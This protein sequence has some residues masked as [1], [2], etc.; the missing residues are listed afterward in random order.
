MSC[1]ASVYRL[2]CPTLLAALK[3]RLDDAVI[4]DVRVNDH[5]ALRVD[6]P[7]EEGPPTWARALASMTGREV[8]LLRRSASALLLVDLGPARYA[9][10]FGHGRRM[11][12]DRAY[13]T[14]FGL[15]I[16]LRCL[17]S[18]Q[19]REVTR[20]ELT[21]GARL[22]LTHVS[23]GTD[24]RTFGIEQAV[25]VVRQLGGRSD[26]LALN[27]LTG[28]ATIQLD[29]RDA[30]KVPLA[31]EPERL[32]TD[33]CAIEQAYHLDPVPE[34]AFIEAL[35][36]LPVGTPAAGA[37]ESVLAAALAYPTNPRLGLTLPV[38]LLGTDIARYRIDIGGAVTARSEL[39]L[40]AITAPLS[41]LPAGDRIAALY[42][43]TVD[44]EPADGGDPR[45][46]P[47]AHWLA[48]DLADGED[49][50][51]YQYGAFYEVTG[52]YRKALHDEATR[53]MSINHP[54]ALPP[55]R[56]GTPERDFN[57][58]VGRQRGWLCLDRDLARSTVHRRGIEICD[59]VAPDGALVCVKRADSSAPLSHLF[60]QA[61]VAAEALRD[62][63]ARRWLTDRLPAGQAD[64][65]PDNPH[66]VFAVQLK[67][68][69]LTPD[70]LFTFS[71][72]TLHRAANHLERL[73]MRVSVIDIPA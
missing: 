68:R 49:R 28:R 59:L 8:A 21:T 30:L 23:G 6:R 64:L 54:W 5:P 26:A 13:E 20:T 38:D 27:Q 37:A 12:A 17:R 2:V 40:P 62:G 65:V 29:G 33:L 73:G 22:D 16:A 24:V 31:A 63:E 41:H 39:D 42:A 7:S 57:D 55:W 11:L 56:A 19:I 60:S 72:V 43:G 70:T 69:T 15:R 66:F 71:L 48:A 3:P 45:P 25:E 51:I 53:L 50:Y 47:A 36:P 32:I 61:V 14:G 52:A 10:A 46:T 18:D 4:H 67:G 35:R 58:M 1:V 9:I 44:A 34:L